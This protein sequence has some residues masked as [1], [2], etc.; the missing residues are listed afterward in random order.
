MDD[1]F[2]ALAAEDED[3]LE[4]QQIVTDAGLKV[5]RRESPPGPPAGEIPFTSSIAAAIRKAGAPIASAA[6]TDMA[7]A[8]RDQKMG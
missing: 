6:L 2:A 3:A 1:Y 4:I 8:F 5:A 7:V